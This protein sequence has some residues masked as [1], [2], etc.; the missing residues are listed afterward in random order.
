MRR[1]AVCVALLLGGGSL[2]VTAQPKAAVDLSDTLARVAEYV[3]SY[4]ARAQS[5]ICDETV[6]VQALGYDLLSDL[7]PG[8]T[9]EHELR[10]SW[11]ASA[12]GSLATPQVLRNLLRVNGRPPREKDRD[13]CFDP[14]A[15]SPEVLG[16]FLPENQKQLTFRLA[17]RTRSGGRPAFLLE[18]RDREDGPV[19]VQANENCVRFGKPGGSWWQAWVDAE[20]HAV[21]RLDEHLARPYDVTVPA[22]PKLRTP[23]MD[24]M[25]ERV[26][27]SIVYR[28]VTFTDP[29][30]TVLLPASKESVQVIRNSPSPRMRTSYTYRNYRRFMTSGRIVQ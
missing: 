9:L 3:Q 14:Q 24:V 13:K 22:N 20:T 26:D 30:E 25:V 11:E 21:L 19:T 10:V 28:A 16:I 8:R 2:T 18:V 7:T 15:T 5:I 6:R 17:N 27:T 23:R 4:F 12:D 29:D 1:V